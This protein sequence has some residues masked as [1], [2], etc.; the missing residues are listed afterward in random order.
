MKY[1]D[2]DAIPQTKEQRHNDKKKIEPEST[3]VIIKLSLGRT[4]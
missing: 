2:I 3:M 4:R 1:W